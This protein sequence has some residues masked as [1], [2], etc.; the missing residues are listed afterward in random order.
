MH[1]NKHVRTCEGVRVFACERTPQADG[2][3]GCQGASG[4]S[5]DRKHCGDRGQ[6]ADTMAWGQDSLPAGHERR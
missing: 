5:V 1:V 3:G 6:S 4:R 2:G